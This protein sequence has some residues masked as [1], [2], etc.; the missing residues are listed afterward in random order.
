MGTL[1]NIY[2][3]IYTETDGFQQCVIFLSKLNGTSRIL[4]R[5]R[6]FRA[7]NSDPSHPDSILPSKISQNGSSGQQI[8]RQMSIWVEFLIFIYFYMVGIARSPVIACVF[9]YV[10]YVFPI[11]SMRWPGNGAETVM[12][13]NQGP[14]GPIGEAG[15]PGPPGVFN[16]IAGRIIAIWQIW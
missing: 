13:A 9:I 10:L 12:L 6:G 5:N 3:Y 11:S 1:S 4:T 7:A 8:M 14:N 2:I 16:S 15:P